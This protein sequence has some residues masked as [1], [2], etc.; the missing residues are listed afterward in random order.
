MSLDVCQTPVPLEKLTKSIRNLAKGSK[1]L[2]YFL[3][4]TQKL[5][6]IIK[7]EKSIVNNNIILGAGTCN[8]ISKIFQENHNELKMIFA[9]LKTRFKEI[10][11]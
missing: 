8:K 10:L 4:D 9:V 2:A 3:S 6:Q 5:L 1:V 7:V 11:I